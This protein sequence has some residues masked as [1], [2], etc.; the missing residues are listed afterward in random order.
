VNDLPWHSP[1]LTNVTLTVWRGGNGVQQYGNV[2]VMFY[3][4]PIATGKS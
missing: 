4:F 2:S 3:E 1:S